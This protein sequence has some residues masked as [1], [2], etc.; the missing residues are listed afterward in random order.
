MKLSNTYNR[1]ESYT[2]L[3]KWLAA[4]NKSRKVKVDIFHANT[5]GNLTYKLTPVLAG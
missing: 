2:F 1:F 4:Y 5:I 3:K